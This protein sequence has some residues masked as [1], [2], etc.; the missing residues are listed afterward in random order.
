MMTCII[1]SRVA[2]GRLGNHWKGSLNY[3]AF[4]LFP[5]TNRAFSLLRSKHFSSI[6]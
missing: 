6:F 3:G 1:K 4:L 5:Y 2:G